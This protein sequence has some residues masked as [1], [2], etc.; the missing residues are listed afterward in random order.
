MSAE[1]SPKPPSMKR[2]RLLP[3]R[4]PLHFGLLMATSA[5]SLTLPL[6][7][8]VA[9]LAFL[10][11]LG[12]TAWD[13]TH[14]LAFAKQL[15]W[16]DA[17][18]LGYL[19]AGAVT[20]IFMLRPLLPH[21]RRKGVALQITP[22]SQ[23][24]IY[25]MVDELC[26]HLR[27]DPVEEI[28]LDTTA[29]IRTSVKDGVVGVSSGQMILN[30]GLPVVSVTSA[31]ELA[32]LLVRE[33]AMNAGGIG[34]TFSHL[35]RELNTWFYRALMERDP[36]EMDMRQAR[37]KETKFQAFIRKVTWL[38]MTV[39]KVLF[40]FFFVIARLV[41]A[42]ALMRL[43]SGADIAA[44]NL[45][46]LDAWNALEAKM[47][48]L[49]KAW[50]ASKVEVRRGMKQNR[51]PENLSLLLARHVARAARDVQTTQ[52]ERPSGKAPKGAEIIAELPVDAP[53]AS[54]FRSFVDLS[55]QVTFFYYQ[56]ELG[57]S[58]LEHRMVAEEEV[59]HQNRREDE[60]LVVIRRYFGGLAHPERAM[61]GL[62]GTHATAPGGTQL[63]DE[64]QRV[65]NEMKEWGSRLKM[66]LQE[67]NMAWQRRRD[68]E[69]AATLSLAGFTVSRI[70][71]GTEDTSPESLRAEGARQR[72][73]MEHVETAIQAYEQRM[74]SRFAAALGLLW[75]T[76]DAQLDDTLSVRK[77]DLPQWCLVYESL[78]SAL[79]SFREL[80]TTFFAFQTLGAKFANLNDNGSF[81]AALQS[82]VPKMTNLVRQILGALDGAT[83]PFTPN[84]L[85]IPMN[86]YLLQ[87]KLPEPINVSMN[88]GSTI[89][90]RAL[91]AEMAATSSEVIAPFVDRFLHLYHKSYAWLAESA[92]RTENHFLS[93][94][95][96]GADVE[97]LMPEEFAKMRETQP[98]RTPP[99]LP[100]KA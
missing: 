79:P 21:P 59:I 24:D 81:F 25:Q 29:S 75:W 91:S 43:Q 71:F 51:L 63:Q 46:G 2:V 38:W 28:W 16:E 42:A 86:D 89:D 62:G 88:P 39:A 69:A 35:V 36:W 94:L 95:S 18:P 54:Q 93:P 4:G 66:A 70:Q 92:E 72:M 67:W 34:T 8:T 80:L 61:C 13:W 10:G 97:L 53:A 56:H 40:A 26:W 19:A 9:L 100:R 12:W 5:V 3:W 76:P 73:V 78:A 15:T 55:R 90:T 77:K 41:N 49:D 11:Y 23:P 33:L 44:K 84:K 98:L 83:Y 17:L 48:L 60:S 20:W 30:I 65:R 22:A 99:V 96:M 58:L 52:S 1:S 85:P 74:E 64:I 45:I 47:G 87:G 50:D 7:Y 68:L 37:A 14:H 6:L 32:S 31:R 57:V 27:L 82:V